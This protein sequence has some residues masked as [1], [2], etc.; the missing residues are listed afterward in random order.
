MK[1]IVNRCFSFLQKI[2]VLSIL[3]GML[4][5]SNRLLE[6]YLLKKVDPIVLKETGYIAAMVFIFSFLLQSVFLIIGKWDY[7]IFAGNILSYSA[8]VGNF[9]LMGI[10]I[11]ASMTKEEKTA[12]NLMKLSR[13]L[14]LF[15]IF[16]IVLVAALLPF[17]NIIA[18][19]IPLLFPRIAIVLR[20]VFMK[21]K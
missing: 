17:F 2:I 14:R 1:S 4:K 18:V 13:V 16:I 19:L 21:K 8:S 9:F 12:K 3:L 20:P 7:T 6:E 15:M 11:Q 10:S 5:N